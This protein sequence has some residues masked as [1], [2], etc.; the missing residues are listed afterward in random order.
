MT[1]NNAGFLAGVNRWGFRGR[2]G[3]DSFLV[4]F[5][6]QAPKEPQTI[7]QQGKSPQAWLSAMAVPGVR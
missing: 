4:P 2:F 7:S 3:V 6:H 1:A 5:A